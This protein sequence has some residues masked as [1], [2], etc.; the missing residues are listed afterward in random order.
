MCLSGRAFPP[1]SLR[2]ISR[3]TSAREAH[4]SHVQQGHPGTRT[5]HTDSLVAL[6]CVCVLSHAWGKATGGKA[7]AASGQVRP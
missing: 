2:L 3:N 4:E 1:A 7:S 5:P 6:R